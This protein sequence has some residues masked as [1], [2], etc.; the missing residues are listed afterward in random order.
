MQDSGNQIYE[1]IVRLYPFCRSITGNG[2]RQTFRIVQEYI[3]LKVREVPSG[4]PVFDWTVPNEWNVWDACIKDRQG[5][6]IVDFQA[7][8]LHLVGYSCPVHRWIKLSELKEHLHT[9][10][11]H[12]QWIPYRTSYYKEDWGFCLAQETLNA[13]QDDEYEVLID[14]RLEPGHLT[15]AEYYLPGETSSEF[16]I[17]CHS[18]HP[19]LCND[20]LSG[21]ALATM[22]ARHLS[23]VPR[24]YS[25]R[26]LFLPGTIGSITWLSQNERSIDRVKHGLVMACLGD[27]GGLHLKKSRRGDA[28]IDR[29]FSH[30]LKTSGDPYEI[31]EF[32][33][34]GYDERQYCSPGFDL[35]VA[36]IMRT[37]HGQFPQYHTSADNLDF[38]KPASLAD[39][40]D[41]CLQVIE[42]IEKN[43][44]YWNLNPKCE[45]QL[46]KRGLYRTTGGGKLEKSDEVSLLWV[47]NWSDGNHDL[48]D[49][50][51]RSGLKFRSISQASKSLASAQLLKEADDSAS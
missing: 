48:L 5:K 25:F 8:N 20:N 49:I 46:G 2:V 33:P 23:S 6:R 22:L 50:A 37:P 45:P 14:S 42:V 11:D 10:P 43:R 29:A 4:T 38:I 28:E 13:M 15:Y 30:V 3:P 7:S 32:S 21:I 19:S 18:C 47:L 36:C 31:M 17:S 24:R 39:S 9:L 34:Y 27:S 26:F 1:L 44:R 12:P 16:L 51:Q 40:F 41:K 35:P